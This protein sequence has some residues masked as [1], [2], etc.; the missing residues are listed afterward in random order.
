MSQTYRRETPLDEKRRLSVPIW[1]DNYDALW[2]GFSGTS[3][4][5]DPPPQAGNRFFHT[6]H[7]CWYTYQTGGWLRDVRAG[8]TSLVFD[9]IADLRGA[10]GAEWYAS[11][12]RARLM[13]NAA[14]GDRLAIDLKWDAASTITGGALDNTDTNFRPTVGA[15]ASGAGRW[16]RVSPTLAAVRDELKVFN[17]NSTGYVLADRAALRLMTWSGAD[18]AGVIVL[19]TWIHAGDPVVLWWDSADTTTAD[20]GVTCIVDVAGNR[21]KPWQV[22]KWDARRFG[23][24][25]DDVNDDRAAIQAA[26]DYLYSLGGNHTLIYPEGVARLSGPIT[27]KSG[28]NNKGQGKQQTGF[29][30]LNAVNTDMWLS[31][32]NVSGQGGN[33]AF[34]DL[35]FDGNAANQSA[36]NGATFTKANRLAFRNVLFRDF[37]GAGLQVIGTSAR[38]TFDGDVEDTGKGGSVNQHGIYCAESVMPQV[39]GRFENMGLNGCAVVFARCEDGTVTSP[40]CFNSTMSNYP[41]IRFSN[42]AKR[43]QLVGGSMKGFESAL[44]MVAAIRCSAAGFGAFNLGSSAVVVFN[45]SSGGDGPSDGNIIGPFTAEYWGQKGNGTTIAATPGVLIVDSHR[46]K[47]GLGKLVGDSNAQRCAGAYKIEHAGGPSPVGN[48]FADCDSYGHTGT[49]VDTYDGNNFATNVRAV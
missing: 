9:T 32:G 24:R 8:E 10:Y 25:F 38:F 48:E 29:K 17:R 2:T 33:I 23:A 45:D 20:N 16:L 31:D 3:F 11:G 40:V 28:I 42:Q 43:C 49:L 30:L 14:A 19:R 37:V 34:N 36:G 7:Q 39:A 22:Q 35:Y 1:D 5:V 13:G 4:P 41:A 15:A 46:T 21:F 6:G 27:A 12:Q 26:Q 44:M 47:V 18:V